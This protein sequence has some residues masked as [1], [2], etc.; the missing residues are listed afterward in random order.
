MEKSKQIYRW[1]KPKPK[2]KQTPDMDLG[3]GPVNRTWSTEAGMRLRLGEGAGRPREDSRA[4]HPNIKRMVE[5]M[6]EGKQNGLTRM[7]TV[8][9]E[10]ANSNGKVS[11][12]GVDT[13]MST[14]DAVIDVEDK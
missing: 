2:P 5:A 11:S 8:N 14:K 3:P 7:G 1:M 4:S 9:T 13:D 6:G 10:T 12:E